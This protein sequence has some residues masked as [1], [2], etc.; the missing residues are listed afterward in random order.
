MGKQKTKETKNVKI[1]V[2]AQNFTTENTNIEKIFEQIEQ[3]VQLESQSNEVVESNE[4]VDMPTNV[5]QVDEVEQTDD[6]VKLVEVNVEDDKQESMES[7]VDIVDIVERSIKTD[8]SPVAT[9]PAKSTGK[10]VIDGV[11]K[12]VLRGYKNSYNNIEE[13]Y[14]ADKGEVVIYNRLQKDPGRC[15]NLHLTH[16]LLKMTGQEDFKQ[17]KIERKWAIVFN[18]D[19]NFKAVT[20]APEMPILNALGFKWN[21]T[22][23]SVTFYKSDADQDKLNRFSKEDVQETYDTIV[24]FAEESHELYSKNNQFT[25]TNTQSSSFLLELNQV[26]KGYGLVTA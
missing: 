21:E 10:Q 11:I 24:H 1:N 13:G 3:K 7:I 6:V 15:S 12:T 14:I 16:I 5:E 22:L 19:F 18:K 8:I 9:K 23:R 20:N 25:A 26:I 17:V 4:V 2:E